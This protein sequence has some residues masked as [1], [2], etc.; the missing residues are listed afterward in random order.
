MPRPPRALGPHT[1]PGASQ[2]TH[3]VPGQD[4]GGERVGDRF[5]SVVLDRPHGPG[6]YEAAWDGR[7][8]RGSRVARGVYFS[9]FGS[10]AFTRTLKIVLLE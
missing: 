5:G 7:D 1:A 2:R 6:R 10:G 3:L 9:R 4:L 8:R